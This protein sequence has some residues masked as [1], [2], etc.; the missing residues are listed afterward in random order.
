MRN[1]TRLAAAIGAAALV[2][3]ATGAERTHAAGA[4]PSAAVLI[5]AAKNTELDK[6]E[7]MDEL[8]P[9]KVEAWLKK[10]GDNRPIAWRSKVCRAKAEERNKVNA[11]IC[12]EAT[13]RFD[14]GVVLTVGVGFDEE[15][16]RP[17]EKP[18]TIWGAVSV[19]GAPCDFLRHPD[20]IQLARKAIDDMVKAGGRCR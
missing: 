8:R 5:A 1:M 4:R 19:R 2:T 17:Q 3:F 6:F 14:K 11:P 16:V 13:I 18:N 20:Q 7:V 10:L 9:L 15:V 12:V